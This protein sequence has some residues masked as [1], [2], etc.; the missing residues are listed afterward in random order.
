MTR[1]LVVGGYGVFGSRL[2]ER[3]ARESDLEVVVAGRREAKARAAAAALAPT[4]TARVTAAAVDAGTIDAAALSRLA[5]VVVVNAAGPFQS[6]DYHLAE[7]CIAARAHYVD[8]ADARRFVTGI[9]ALDGAAKSAGVAV[10]SGASS[11]PGLSSAVIR[12]LAASFARIRAIDIAI[13]PGN[14]FDP[15]VATTASILS[16]VGR[17]FTA[18]I[19]GATR[20]IHGWQGLARRDF[21]GLGPRWL[22]YA[23]VPDLDLLPERYPDAET[24]RFRAGVE[25]GAFHVGLYALSWL[26]RA[27][28]V[29]DAAAR[30]A[31]PLL[32]MKRRLSFLGSD[33]GGMLVVVEGTGRD[34]AMLKRQWHLVAGSGHGPYVPTLAAVI[35]A[36]RLPRGSA[37]LLG[38]MPCVDLLTPA[39]VAAEVADLDIE[40][41]VA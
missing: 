1:I 34:G 14:S 41:G 29:G 31:R 9:T 18:R 35:L 4:A 38:A 17:P 25:V 7:A 10:I 32:A 12:D 37:D 21:P 11:V 2:A 24:V 30:L 36:K 16:W 5:P 3:L 39:E 13:S 23:D 8:L 28:L 6:Q 26:V 22:G 40:M 15:G 20:T 33:R 19:G 27:G